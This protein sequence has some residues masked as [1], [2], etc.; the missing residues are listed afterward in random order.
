M[1]Q[2]P[3]GFFHLTSEAGELPGRNHSPIDADSFFNPDQMWGGIEPRLQ[4]C[5]SQYR[6]R[7]G[8]HRSFAVGSPNLEGGVFPLGLPQ[9]SEQHFDVFQAQLGREDLIA[10]RIQVVD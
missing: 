4:S 1:E 2:F 7:E 9:V 6:F 10:E 3:D 8:R 5:L